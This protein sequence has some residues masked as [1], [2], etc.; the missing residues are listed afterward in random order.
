MY[1]RAPHSLSSIPVK[2][3]GGW[4][5][6]VFL[7]VSMQQ[8]VCHHLHYKASREETN[9]F[10]HTQTHGKN[11]NRRTNWGDTKTHSYA[12]MPSAI[13]RVVF[14][15]FCYLLPC[16]ICSSKLRKEREW[17]NVPFSVLLFTGVAGR[18]R[19]MGW[20]LQLDAVTR[21]NVTP[22]IPIYS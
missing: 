14:C 9:I 21:L 20:A 6:H 12:N 15:V 13:R 19:Q 7:I 11:N 16:F 4:L 5:L 2:R 8:C 1:F 3:R 10:T 18:L 17:Q 22:P